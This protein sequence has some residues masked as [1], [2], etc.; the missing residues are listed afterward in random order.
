MSVLYHSDKANVVAKT[1]SRSSTGSVS[2]V[3]EF[4]RK[5]VRDVHM[6]ARLGVRI[7]Y[8]LNGGV[9]VYHNSESSLVVEVKSKKHLNPLLIELK[10]LDLWNMYESFF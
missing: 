10:E 5:L 4:K 2:H 8:S 3:E 9:V 1:L 7:E 6:L